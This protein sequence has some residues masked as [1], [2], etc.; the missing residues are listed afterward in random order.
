M[1]RDENGNENEIKILNS[2]LLHTFI[3]ASFVFNSY[4]LQIKGV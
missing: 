3:G 4:V 1:S 2:I